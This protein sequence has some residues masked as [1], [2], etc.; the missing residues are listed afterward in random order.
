MCTDFTNL[1]KSC[2]K[3]DFP[4]T[5]IV[6]VVDFTV[7]CDIMSL[8]DCVSGYHQIWLRKEHK[9]NQLHNTIWHILLHEDARRAAQCRPN[10]LQNDEGGTKGLSQRKHI[11]LC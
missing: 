5:R 4:L 1:N 11:L 6:Q 8:L 7:D 10:V 2:P 3:D 9:K